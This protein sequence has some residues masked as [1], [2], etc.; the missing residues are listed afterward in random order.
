M[1][2]YDGRLWEDFPCDQRYDDDGYHVCNADPNPYRGEVTL[3]EC[4]ECFSGDTA[5]R[6]G[7]A[8]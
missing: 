4:R 3:E 5:D 2:G 7:E 6:E 8:L 1:S